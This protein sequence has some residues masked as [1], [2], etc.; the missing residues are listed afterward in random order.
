MYPLTFQQ[1][2]NYGA[3]TDFSKALNNLLGDQTG[4]TISNRTAQGFRN[5]FNTNQLDE[6][7][8]EHI[9]HIGMVTAGTLIRSNDEFQQTTGFLLSLTLFIC[10]QAG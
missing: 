8:A 10:Y 3:L 9:V 7:D 1:R 5:V 6:G 2:P 4:R